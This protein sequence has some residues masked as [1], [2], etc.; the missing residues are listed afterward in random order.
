MKKWKVDYKI[1]IYFLIGGVIGLFSSYLIDNVQINGLLAWISD[2]KV[3]I[4]YGLLS[5]V[6]ILLITTTFLLTQIL[7]LNKQKYSGEEEDVVEIIK[8]KKSSDYSMLVSVNLVIA[9]LSFSF[10]LL[11][12]VEDFDFVIS[13]GS[14]LIL[15]IA[16]ISSLTPFWLAKKIEPNRNMP[17]VFE[18]DAAK[19]L[20]KI[21]DEDEKHVTFQGLYKAY[22]FL[23]GLLF[24]GILV[25]TL[26]SN[27][28][29]QSQAF[30]ISLMAIT[31]LTS[32]VMYY[33][34]IRKNY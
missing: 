31:L 19:K 18:K 24:I 9:L 12:D 7:K 26:Y 15:I 3:A 5:I 2:V 1:I 13:I 17:S 27:I 6:I 20:I 30:S 16:V 25:A 8:Y 14:P 28:S 34:T 11:I 23:A 21:M 22:N 29:G 33:T 32:H 10:S 4:I